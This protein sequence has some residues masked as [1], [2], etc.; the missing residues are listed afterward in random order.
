[1]EIEFET[2]DGVVVVTLFG[3]LDSRTAPIVQ[4]KLMDLPS[5]EARVLLEMSGVNYISSAG[6]RALLMLYRRMANSD[7]R[8]ALVGLTAVSYTHLDVYKR[9]TAT[10]ML[11][12]WA[13][14]WRVPPTKRVMSPLAA[15]RTGLSWAKP[16]SPMMTV[17]SQ[18][19]TS[20]SSP[21]PSDGMGVALSLIHI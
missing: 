2:V 19:K 10:G 4:D 17:R 5:P 21:L 11:K 8:V 18:L 1:M 3:E 12:M 13:R 16:L 7:G 14:K 6:L 15:G 20:I 9:Q